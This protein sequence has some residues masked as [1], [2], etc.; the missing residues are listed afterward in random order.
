MENERPIQCWFNAKLWAAC[1]GLQKI[2]QTVMLTSR[3]PEGLW[4]F[5]HNVWCYQLSVW[6]LKYLLCRSWEN[7]F[8]SWRKRTVEIVLVW[9]LWQLEQSNKPPLLVEVVKRSSKAVLRPAGHDRPPECLRSCMEGR[10]FPQPMHSLEVK[11]RESFFYKH[12]E[13]KGL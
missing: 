8:W 9:V 13:D 3:R 7:H 2:I 4:S 5:I 6:I 12:L 11:L 10:Y 1:R